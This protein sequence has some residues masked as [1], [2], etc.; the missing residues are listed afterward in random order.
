[1]GDIKSVGWAISFRNGG[2]DQ[3]V[4]VG[5]IARNSH[6]YTMYT[7]AAAGQPY[8]LVVAAQNSDVRCVCLACVHQGNG[9]ARNEKRRQMALGGG[10]GGK[11]RS[12]RRGR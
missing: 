7:N 12:G 4:E 11:G 3:I 5:D 9:T 8:P 2:R 1:V 10:V 6:P